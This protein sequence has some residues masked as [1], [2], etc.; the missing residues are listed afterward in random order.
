ML[1]N[2]EDLSQEELEDELLA[3]Q[4]KYIEC[5]ICEHEVGYRETWL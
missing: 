2:M 1:L 4:N 3:S 5:S